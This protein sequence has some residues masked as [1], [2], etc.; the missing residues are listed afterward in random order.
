MRR[1]HAGR[2][3]AN[4]T[5]IVRALRD[6]GASVQSLASVGNGCVDLLVG[7]RNGTWI[8]E[9]KT[10]DGTLTPAEQRWHAN[11]RGPVYIV[12]SPDEALQVIGAI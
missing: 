10:E 11:W 12:R 9:I 5:A 1:G 4:H 8:M 6:V 7:W 2:T 3:D